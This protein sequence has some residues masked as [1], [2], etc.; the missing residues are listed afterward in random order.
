MI[1]IL[2]KAALTWLFLFSLLAMSARVVLA[3]DYFLTVGGGYNP[4]GNQASLEANVLFFQQILQEK[5]HGPRSHDVYFA[6]GDDTAAD[7]QVLATRPPQDKL[8]A[9]EIIAMLHRR[10]G[11]EKLEYRNHVVPG[12]RGPLDPGLIRTDIENITRKAQAGDRLIVYVTAHGSPGGKGAKE[13]HNTTIDCWKQRRITAREFTRWLNGLPPEVPVILVM[14]QCYCG[15][16]AHTIFEDLD[17]DKGLS[18]HVRA[19]FFAQQHN[20]PAAGC[21][22]D[23]SNDAEFSSYFWGAIAGRTRTGVATIDCDID[24]NGSISFS[25]AYA[26]AVIASPTIDIP[27]RSSEALLRTYS[28]MAGDDDQA[29]DRPADADAPAN[30]DRGRLAGLS[31][32]LRTWMQQSRPTSARIVRGLSQELGLNLDED[33][34]KVAAALAEHRRNNRGAGRGTGGRRRPSSGRRELLQEI[35]EKWPDLGDARNW[36]ESPLLKEDNQQQI[37]DEIKL[38]PSWKTFDDR[39]QQ[40]AQSADQAEQHELREVKYRR[41]INTLETIV[42]ETNLPNVATRDVVERYRQIVALEDSSFDPAT[43]H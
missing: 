1:R 19:G 20:L 13:T 41:L 10:R 34:T 30:T 26:H 14:A 7:L 11:E 40:T 22:P 8:S 17:P 38:L 9:T 15:G 29:P 16:F 43:A 32:P 36:N 42:L 24:G 25:E 28:R 27:L 6:D 33:V 23:I 35:T 2:R 18:T 21:R 31:G 4:S 3:T 37:L 12:V 39:R 5:H